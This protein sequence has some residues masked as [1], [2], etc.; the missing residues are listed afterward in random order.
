MVKKRMGMVLGTLISAAVL[1]AGCSGGQSNQTPTPKAGTTAEAGLQSGDKKEEPAASN[2]INIE[3]MEVGWFNTPTDDNNPRKKWIDERYNVDFKLFAYPGGDLESKLLVRF[4][5]EEHP[6]MIH[7][8]DKKLVDKLYKQGVLIDDWT[9]YLDKLPN[10]T[11]GWTEPLKLYASIDGKL[12]G[13]PQK[14]GA[15]TWTMMVRQDW[16][17]NLGLSKP[18]TDKELLDVLRKFTFNDPDKNGKND[19]YGISSAGSGNT[20]GEITQFEAM[21]GHYSNTGFSVTEGGKLEHSITNGTHHKFL[22]FMRTVVKE[23]LIDPDWYTQG[24]EQRKPRLFSGKIGVVYYPSAIVQEAENANGLSGSTI[25][26]WD[27][28]PMPSGGPGGGKR[29]ATPIGNGFLT[30]S[31]KAAKDPEKMERILQ[32]INTTAYPSDEYDTL[33]FGIGVSGREIK[34]I[35]GGGRYVNNLADTYAVAQPG[36]IDWGVWIYNAEDGM[37]GIDGDEP[38]QGIKRMMELDRKALTYESYRNYDELLSLNTQIVTDLAK[39]S[40][41]FDIS[42]VLGQETDYAAF[43]QKWLKEGG[44]K[45]I[46]EATEQLGKLDMLNE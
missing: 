26:W 42:Y 2:K 17:Q 43:E 39:I 24:W 14:A 9:P 19:T 22:D 30:V 1:T 46:D 10:L 36:V 33:R 41:E 38:G 45:L 7:T 15:N 6:D 12:V 18:A 40:Q 34:N 16:L 31:A 32:I 5:S 20:M 35:E 25:G 4:A 29:P 21:F 37:V 13:L 23:K 44:Q 3:L 28:A 11:K 8:N 27:S